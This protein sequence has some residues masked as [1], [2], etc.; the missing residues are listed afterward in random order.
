MTIDRAIEILNHI[1]NDF[2]DDLLEVLTYMKENI[3]DFDAV[4]KRAFRVVFLEM[5]KLFN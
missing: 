3:D 4:E 5:S 2:G 1:G